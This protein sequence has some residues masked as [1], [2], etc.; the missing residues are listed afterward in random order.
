MGT[1]QIIKP[2]KSPAAVG[3]YNHAESVGDLLFCTGQIPLNPADGSLITG[4]IKPRP[5]VLDC[6]GKRSATP[7]SQQSLEIKKRC[8]RCALPPHCKSDAGG[9][10]EVPLVSGI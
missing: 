1:K 10:G 3:A 5:S 9:C 4:D 7:L 2:A 6:G 8:R